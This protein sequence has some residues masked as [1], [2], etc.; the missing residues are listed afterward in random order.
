MNRWLL[1][2]VAA[3]ATASQ[4]LAVGFERVSVPDGDNPA[5]EAGIWYPSD[6][7]VSAQSLGAF[8]QT[9][10]P[11]AAVKGERL[12]LIVFSHGSGGS[13]EG[14][15][16]TA[17]ALAE[18]GFVVAGV[19]HTGDNYRD[20][21]ALT[22]V[23]NRPRHIKRLVDFMVGAW[24]QRERIDTKRIGMF[25]FSAGGFTTL[26]VIGANPDLARVAPYCA[27]NPQE[28]ACQKAAG[29]RI[30]WATNPVTFE[31]DARITAAVIAAPALGFSLTPE[32]LRNITVPVQLWRGDQ[33]EILPHPRHAQHIYDSLPVK[34]DYRVVA[35]AGHFV[36]LA[37]CSPALERVAPAICQDPKGF[38]RVAFHREF[39]AAAVA[40]LKAKLGQTM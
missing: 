40:F 30:D 13:F 32:G 14:H 11:G 16:D 8:Q 6:A 9:V 35:N 3:L 1:A 15:Y 23:D 33:D 38:D 34:P 20:Q 39:N 25:G 36:F 17:I 2:I 4:A 28:W 7:A 22:R 26:A 19:T 27:A 10:A 24:P 21:S 37:P 12:P 5:L 31:H 29:T 18:A